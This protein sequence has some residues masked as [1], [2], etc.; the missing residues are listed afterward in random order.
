MYTVKLLKQAEVDFAEACEWYEGERIGLGTRFYNA[1][2]G[3]LNRIE[4]N[5]LHYNVRFSEI[6]RVA[7]VKGFPYVIV[8]R[9]NQKTKLVYVA[10]I[11]HTSRN[12]SKF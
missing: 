9:V 1:V 6:Y 8:Y 11:F 10:S 5:P 3:K 7:K 2:S 4:S 12:P